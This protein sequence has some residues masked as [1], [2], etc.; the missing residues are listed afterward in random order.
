MSIRRWTVLA[1]LAAAGQVYGQEARTEQFSQPVKLTLQQE[2]SVYALPTPAREEEGINQ[3]GINLDMTFA[4]LNDY[5]FRGVE[6]AAFIAAATDSEAGNANFQFDGTMKLNLGRLPH[7]FIGIFANVLDTDEISNF[8]EVRPF[9]GAEWAIRPVILTAGHNTYVFPDRD[10]LNTGEAFFKLTIDDAAVLK[11]D[12]PLLLPY[13]YAAYD[14]DNY[15]GWYLEAGVS[16]DFVIEGTGLT[17][18][19]LGHVAYVIGHG[20]FAGLEGEDSGFQ[21]WQVGVIGRYNLNNL[22]NIP[23]RY[24]RWSINGYLYYTDQIDDDLRADNELWGGAGVQLKY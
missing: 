9:I 11:R 17:I 7:P 19:A 5:I 6:R 4:Y 2:P 21:H 1:A 3:G 12:E 16:H 13:I 20:A 18:T 23:L 10:E 15:D 22:L 14:Y 8:Q 24:G